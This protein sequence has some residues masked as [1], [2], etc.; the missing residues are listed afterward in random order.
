[1]KK[2]LLAA[3]ALV[4]TSAFALATFS[5]GSNAR[6]SCCADCD[7]TND[8][9]SCEAGEPCVCDVGCCSVSCCGNETGKTEQ[10]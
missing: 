3:T 6:L 5:N 8:S 2:L 4:A 9:C 1:M 10:T 7:C